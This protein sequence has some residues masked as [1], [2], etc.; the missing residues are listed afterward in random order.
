MTEETP[1]ELYHM[2]MQE[3]R[4]ARRLKRRR[5]KMVVDGAGIKKLR[6]ISRETIASE[7]QKPPKP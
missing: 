1:D 6:N 7:R 4:D 5:T 2:H 3:L